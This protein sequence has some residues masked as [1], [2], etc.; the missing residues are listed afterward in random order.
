MQGAETGPQ[1]P[2]A[3]QKGEKNRRA[4]PRPQEAVRK[5]QMSTGCSNGRS[6][7]TLKGG[8]SAAGSGDETQE[9]Q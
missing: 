1:A 9:G 7:V 6:E 2:D 5:G 3:G 8:T 4:N